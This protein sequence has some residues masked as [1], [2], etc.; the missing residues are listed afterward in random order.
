MSEILIPAEAGTEMT[1]AVCE[2]LTYL[3]RKGQELDEEPNE[4]VI[5]DETDRIK[6]AMD[7]VDTALKGLRNIQA[8][9]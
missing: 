1:R 9:I 7:F 8:S 5:N 6:M 2:F 3:D 4:Y